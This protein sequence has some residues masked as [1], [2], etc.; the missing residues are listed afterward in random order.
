MIISTALHL[1]VAG[2]SPIAPVVASLRPTRG[3]EVPW[4]SGHALFMGQLARGAVLI[5]V[6]VLAVLLLLPFK[7]ESYTHGVRLT[8]HGTDLDLVAIFDVLSLV[9]LVLMADDLAVCYRALQ[10]TMTLQSNIPPEELVEDLRKFLASKGAD[11]TTSQTRPGPTLRLTNLTL[12]DR[13][14]PLRILSSPFPGVMWGGANSLLAVP[15]TLF[16]HP[17]WGQEIHRAVL[18]SLGWPEDTPPRR[19][20]ADSTS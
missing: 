9:F 13:Y 19:D 3:G 20:P 11:V 8:L 10:H 18:H 6:D 15:Q 1:S 12:R 17:R 5:A 14:A 7:I 4:Q 16:D 2:P